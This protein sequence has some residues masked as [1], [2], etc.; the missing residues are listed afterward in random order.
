[1]TMPFLPYRILAIALAVGLGILAAGCEDQARV[2]EP[3]A[4][5]QP[6]AAG[7][8]PAAAA[9]QPPEPP[10]QAAATV[11]PGFVIA[12]PMR[13]AQTAVRVQTPARTD[14]IGEGKTVTRDVVH[15]RIFT[16]FGVS[17]GETISKQT[18]MSVQQGQTP[19]IQINPYGVGATAGGPSTFTGGG[20]KWTWWDTLKTRMHDYGLG[21]CGAVIVVVSLG[22]ILYVLVPGARPVISGFLRLIASVPPF[23]GS[24][25]ENAVGKA[26]EAAV[27][28]P[29]TEVV[30]GGQQFKDLVAREPEPITRQRVLD[31]FLAAHMAAQDKSTQGLVKAIKADL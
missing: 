4:G 27:V 6:V 22:G 10:E 15:A 28:K 25:V 30:D 19:G 21:I 31:L 26:K 13:E 11:P 12:A 17:P 8:R 9:Q 7:E 23:V 1:M 16:P 29:L 5:Q 3:A 20:G 24:L 14:Y 2:D 18:P